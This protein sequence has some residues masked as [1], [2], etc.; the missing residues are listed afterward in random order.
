MTANQQQSEAWNGAESVHYVDQADRYDRQLAPIADALFDVVAAR[1]PIAVLDVGCG[2][3]ST[4]LSAARVARSALGVDLSKPLL[5]VAA[6]RARAES[7]DNAEF[8]VAHAETH[9]FAAGTFDLV[10]ANSV[11]CSSMTPWPCSQTFDAR[12]RPAVRSP[13]RVGKGSKPT[14][15]S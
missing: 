13:S 7:V 8:V 14:N 1:T 15:G 6:S 2:C 12:L 5:E 3:G 10:I 4:T 9:A 11:S